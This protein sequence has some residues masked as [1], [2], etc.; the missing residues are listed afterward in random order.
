M[1]KFFPSSVLNSLS[2]LELE[3]L[4]YI[5]NHKN[6]ICDMP[7]QILAKNTF[8]STT[9]I[10]RLCHKLNL[11][12]FSHLKFFIKNNALKNAEDSLPVKAFS[13]QNTIAEE[14]S[15]IERTSALLDEA[16]IE[17]VADIMAKSL[18]IH[19]FC[20]RFNRINARI[21]RQASPVS[22]QTCYT[23]SGHPYCLYS[24]GTPFR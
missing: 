16:V 19:F 21:Y 11:E 13:V 5:D 10:I 18:Q 8:V 14:L 20:E 9:T 3:I 4:R 17:K 15:D 7:I 22:I 12:G 6:E 1:F 24:V 2:S 23:L